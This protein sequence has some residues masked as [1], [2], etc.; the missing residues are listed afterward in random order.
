MT[1]VADESQCVPCRHRPRTE[2][3]CAGFSQARRLLGASAVT[4]SGL[5][6][7]VS[8]MSMS[9]QTVTWLFPNPRHSGQ[10][11]FP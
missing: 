7:S 8:G 6:L 1:Y 10:A 3:L 11:T 9:P 4:E 5:E 2:A